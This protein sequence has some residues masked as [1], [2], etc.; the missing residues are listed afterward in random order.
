MRVYLDSCVIIY[1]I[2]GPLDVKESV[3]RAFKQ[4]NDALFLASDL[5]RMECRV[6][7]LRR[8]QASVLAELDAFFSNVQIALPTSA[9]FDLAA[10]LRAKHTIRTP[11]AIHLALALEYDCDEFWTSDLRLAR[12]SAAIRFRT[13]PG[14]DDAAPRASRD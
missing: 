7:P 9:V 11:D 12:T 8:M 4:A 14:M 6:G 10:E 1:L 13:F 2:E 5:V 3:S